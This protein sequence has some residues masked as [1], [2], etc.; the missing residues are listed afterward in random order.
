MTHLKKFSYSD[1]SG[2]WMIYASVYLLFFISSFILSDAVLTYK[3]FLPYFEFTGIIVS[4]S[5]LALFLG[6]IAGRIIYSKVRL[7]RTFNVILSLLLTAGT[8]L[9]FYKHYI[10]GIEFND[11]DLYMR[12]RYIVYLVLVTPM[13]IAGI[14]NTYLLKV[15]CGDFVDEKN[16]LNQYHIAIFISITTAL[17]IN[18]IIRHWG[19]NP[20]LYPL[21]PVLMAVALSIFSSRLTMTYLPDVLLAKH[22]PDEEI[23]EEESYVHRDDLLFTYSSF[24]FIII[25]FFLGY[26][27]L[28]KFYG[29]I[30]YYGLLY[31]AAMFLTITL[32]Y[33]C[34]R[35][36]RQS[37]WYV[38]SEMLYPVFFT[39]SLIL[40]YQFEHIAGTR[41][42]ILIISIPGLIFGFSLSST[43]FNIFSKYDHQRR[44]NIIQFT[45]FIIPLPIFVAAG[46]LNF[47]HMVF[48]IILYVIAF[49]NLF[50]PAIFLFN[51]KINYIKKTAY[52]LI[53]LLFIPAIILFHLY[54]KIPVDTKP[55][56]TNTQNYDILKTTNYNMLYIA[57]EGEISLTG[58]PAFY[59]SESTIRNHKRAAA[60]TLLFIKPESKGLIIDSNQKFFRNPLFG[61][62]KN[63]VCL[64]NVPER[65]VDFNRLPES[66]RQ[67]Y[68]PIESEILHYLADHNEQY[69]FIIDYPNLLDQTSHKFRF[70]RGYYNAINRHISNSGKYAVI[71]DIQN[72]DPSI[73]NYT[74]DNISAS[75]KKH[76]VFLFSNILLIVASNDPD[77]IQTD[78]QSIER[79]SSVIA[80]EE[81]YGLLFY[82][83][84]QPLN[85]YLFAD[86]ADIKKYSIPSSPYK[87]LT[88]IKAVNRKIT[89][90]FEEQYLKKEPA[91]E[92]IISKN[93]LG[94]EIQS[95]ILSS[96]A[97]EK[98]VMSL[99][100]KTE[101][102]ESIHSY[103]TE[104]DYLFQLKRY[105]AYNS[106][107]K[108]YIDKILSFKEKFYFDEAV[109]LEKDKR[110]DDAATLYKAILTINNTNFDANYRLGMLY[111]TMQDL[112]NAFIYLDSAL[113]L[114]KEHPQVL[115]QMGVLMFSSNK[116]KEAIEYLEK[117]KDLKLE[118]YQLYMYLGLS[119]E[120]T[121]NFDKAKENYEKAILQD[122]NDSKLRSLLAGIEL[123]IKQSQVI[124]DQGSQD[125][126][127]DDEQGVKM[128]IPVNKKAIK[129]RLLDE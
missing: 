116:I 15:S 119:Y 126:M 117:A 21:I 40:L 16:L 24:S 45:L 17:A 96:L 125:N 64:D 122:P 104:T 33:L 108:T 121:E 52:M 46:F 94:W 7:L 105:G 26:I 62:Y 19:L 97:R 106:D 47:T 91:Y 54:F 63:S 65:F 103:V 127:L 28:I 12:N 13:F 4:L 56:F 86:V 120:Q 68:I 53:A 74:V 75:F 67:L 70:S 27:V 9:L 14:I 23:H 101:Y 73:L 84:V 60:A 30:Y 11:F 1:T 100:K 37:F 58:I 61:I 34:G 71:I 80:D 6:N 93:K 22:Y 115:Y 81:K 20:L 25:Y 69:D 78:A 123:K 31:T 95:K 49:V 35:F 41:S 110:W 32:G 72:I 18:L 38:Y 50:I 87:L 92:T 57:E 107:L 114:N 39:F 102:A 99:I 51:L 89:P 2:R 113:K 98:S 55:F 118:I 111:I 88:I 79:I 29:N 48:F 77:A 5:L 82:S 124:D 112:S 59:L 44:F 43:V 109:R 3:Q 8:I 66:G 42:G 85:N 76:S 36:S 10:F 83:P 128:S 90:E 129:A